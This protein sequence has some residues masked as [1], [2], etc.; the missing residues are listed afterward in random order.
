MQANIASDEMKE[1]LA[2]WLQSPAATSKSAGEDLAW[3]NAMKDLSAVSI[4]P[5]K[6]A[7]S[8]IETKQSI[9]TQS[10]SKPKSAS[11]R[12]VGGLLALFGCTTKRK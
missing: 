7:Q 1:Q 10:S 12:G 3:L 8:Q 11:G 4:D 6:K 2:K 9:E 5:E